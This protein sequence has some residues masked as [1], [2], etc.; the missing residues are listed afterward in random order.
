[1]ANY[2]TI[3]TRLIDNHWKNMSNI[4]SSKFL[5]TWPN[6][7]PYKHG[8]MEL[9]FG[10]NPSSRTSAEGEIELFMKHHGYVRGEDYHIPAWNYSPVR[11]RYD[12]P[13]YIK[14]RLIITFATD[15]QFVMAKMA[16]GLQDDDE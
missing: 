11:Y 16:W 3:P 13:E 10:Y 7:R 4:K 2:N 1:M 14:D 8:A 5:T 15:E 9:S 12:Y 6:G